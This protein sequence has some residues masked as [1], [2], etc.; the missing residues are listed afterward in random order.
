MTILQRTRTLVTGAAIVAVAV[1]APDA[2]QNQ[3]AQSWFFVNA[4]PTLEPPVKGAPY[5]AEGTTTVKMRMFDGTR[6]ERS[7]TAKFFRDSAGRIRREQ[8]VVGLEALDPGKDFRAVVTIVDH[9]AGFI[10]TLNPGSRTAH[11]LSLAKVPLQKDPLATVP[12]ASGISR[13]SLGTKDIDGFTAAGQRVTVTIPVGQA[14]NDRPIE[15]SDERWLSED[16]KVVLYSKHSDP[17]SGDVEFKLTKVSRQ[18]PAKDLFLIPAGYTIQ[19][20]QPTSASPR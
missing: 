3:P 5:S 6:I 19:K 18:E 16:L 8:T 11:Q 2:Q 12:I 9:V 1:A 20:V 4:E 7:V 13:Q 14:G 17:R 10:V 15:I